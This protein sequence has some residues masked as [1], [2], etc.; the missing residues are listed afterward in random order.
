[1]LPDWH[2]SREHELLK[3]Q[4]NHIVKIRNRTA[5][6]DWEGSEE[7]DVDDEFRPFSAPRYH[8]VRAPTD[9]IAM[10]HTEK[11]V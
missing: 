10:N 6:E 7:F 1:M 2:A 8:T 11:D 5:G 4:L 3:L 9:P